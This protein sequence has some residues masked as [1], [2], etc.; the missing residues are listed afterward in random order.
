MCYPLYYCLVLKDDIII[1]NV[2]ILF[3]VLRIDFYT[4]AVLGSKKVTYGL[5][6]VRF[7]GFFKV[8]MAKMTTY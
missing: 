8:K 7:Q 1:A 4:R 2:S 6:G 5:A 3:D